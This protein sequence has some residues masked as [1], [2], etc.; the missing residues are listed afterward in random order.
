MALRKHREGELAIEQTRDLARVKTIL[1]DAGLMT[2]GVDWPAACY[3]IAFIGDAPIGV[4]GIEAKVD[5]AIIR[6][7]WVAPSMRRR[8]IG[9]QLLTAARKAAHTRGARHLYLFSTEA[10]DWFRRFGFEEVPIARVVEEL[11]GT[12]QV[13][14]YRARPDELAREVAFHLDISQDGV[15]TR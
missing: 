1:A 13:D 2:D 8:G 4:A 14:Y 7:V 15:I 12:P 3:L 5:A 9:A 11:T 10:G 6:S